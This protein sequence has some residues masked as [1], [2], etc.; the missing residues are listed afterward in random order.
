MTPKYFKPEA[1]IFDKDGTLIDFN[2]M[3]G[4]WATYLADE[5]TSVC[6]KQV[7]EALYLA[8]GYDI[9]NKKVLANGML[10]SNTMENLFQ[11]TI[12]VIQ[13]LGF[14][15]KNSEQIV[16]ETWH[17]PDPVLLAKPFTNLY[18]LFQEINSQGIKIAIATAD[19]R[20]PTESFIQAFDIEQFIE[21]IV[22]ANDGIPSKPNGDMALEISK[23][24][25]IPPQNIMVIGDTVSDLKMA[26]SAGA[27][28]AVGVL[29]GVSNTQDLLPHADLLI[30]SIEELPVYLEKLA[31]VSSINTNNNLNPDF[32]F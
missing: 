8:L 21:T 17:I 7:H 12:M 15:T 3:W 5:I 4:G 6:G 25:N 31:N 18:D 11:K 23:R 13:S 30:E 16:K 29:S 9:Q 22:C 27:G 26:R 14:G 28:L 24:I 1:I 20:V 2:F 32:A 19:D 10:A